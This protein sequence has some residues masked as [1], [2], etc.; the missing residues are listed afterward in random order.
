MIMSSYSKKS[1]GW[2]RVANSLF[3]IL[4]YVDGYAKLFK[5]FCTVWLFSKFI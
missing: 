5:Q 3:P 1:P 2:V 4:V